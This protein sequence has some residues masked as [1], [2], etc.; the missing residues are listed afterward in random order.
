MVYGRFMDA[1]EDIVAIAIYEQKSHH[2]TRYYFCIHSVYILQ[3]RSPQL[4]YVCW[5][6]NPA[7]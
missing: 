4:T 3:E 2:V 1:E 5:F 7:N 6:V